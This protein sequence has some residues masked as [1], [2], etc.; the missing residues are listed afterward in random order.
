[1]GRTALAGILA[2]GLGLA[3][4]NTT[5]DQYDAA[6]ILEVSINEPTKLIETFALV[7]TVSS[8]PRIIE[9]DAEN[10]D[11]TWEWEIPNEYL[12]THNKRKPICA[13]AGL[14]LNNN[15][16]INAL[17][18][19]FGVINVKRN[20]DHKVLITDDNIDHSAQ[21]L[22][23]GNILFS[24]G[25][26]DKSVASFLIKD[27]KNKTIWKWKP[28]DYFQS[29]EDF[30]IPSQTCR[31]ALRNASENERDWA[32]ANDVG[33]LNN[34]NYILSMRNFS[35]FIEI[36]PDG[37]IINKYNKVQ[38]VHQPT[39]YRGGYLVADRNCG[40][41]SLI[42]LA[43]DGTQ[44]KLFTGEFLLIRSIEPLG[45]EHFLITSATTISEISLDGKIHY[46][47]H[48]KGISSSAEIGVT[49]TRKLFTV[50]SCGPKTLY[51]AIP[52]SFKK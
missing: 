15:K 14:T 47:S 28:A 23:D 42:V 16:S 38:G 44:K 24:R 46:K 19:H 4:C 21:Q 30:I 37:K 39:P 32:H 40:E 6:N 35:L 52:T 18:P 27:L 33:V 9:V 10:G 2:C 43:A 17:I 13:G 1:M 41:E 26:V 20:G 36:K 22:N 8:S 34:G 48:V 50:G 11:I 5:T 51:Q 45:G 29:K 3:G 49:N 7:D 31:G 12:K 25:F